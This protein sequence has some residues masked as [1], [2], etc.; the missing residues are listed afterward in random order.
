MRWLGR[1]FTAILSIIAIILAFLGLY[2]NW[3]MNVSLIKTNKMLDDLDKRIETVDRRAEL[4]WVAWNLSTLN[5]SHYLQ[6]AQ[7]TAS[8]HTPRYVIPKP[9]DQFELTEQG[10]QLLCT[11]HMEAI[12]YMVE[13]EP[14]ISD[15]V[16]I[17]RLGIDKLYD[18]AKEKGVSLDDMIGAVVCYI[19]EIKEENL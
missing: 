18:A 19:H 10:R 17:I 7:I 3:Q 12:I 14:D 1:N 13:S 6:V 16:V 9:N 5:W 4:S 15:N 8:N 2:I 11:E